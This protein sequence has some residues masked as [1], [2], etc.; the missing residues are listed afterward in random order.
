MIIKKILCSTQLG[1]MQTVSFIFMKRHGPL[2]LCVAVC[3]LYFIFG[4][5]VF[6]AHT[7]T[8]STLAT[9]TVRCL[10]KVLRKNV[11]SSTK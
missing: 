6:F 11:Y 5:T 1:P 7:H 9:T 3:L 10:L 4:T 2:G 8:R